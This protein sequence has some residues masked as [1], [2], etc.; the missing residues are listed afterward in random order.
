MLALACTCNL[1]DHEGESIASVEK[2]AP[3]R[4]NYKC[5]GKL[6]I[7][8]QQQMNSHARKEIFK[9]WQKSARKIT[10]TLDYWFL[11]I[12]YLIFVKFMSKWLNHEGTF[13][14]EYN[15]I[16]LVVRLIKAEILDQGRIQD[17]VTKFGKVIWEHYYYCLICLWN[18]WCRKIKIDLQ[19]FKII[20][21]EETE[22]FFSLFVFFLLHF[23]FMFIW[24]FLVF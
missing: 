22:P 23:F 5:G 1:H 6:L 20:W 18:I 4:G 3:W 24:E 12:R 15:T 14:F 16:V 9:Y 8:W 7:Y 13:L 11:V 21:G 2:L 17:L 10:N 19:V